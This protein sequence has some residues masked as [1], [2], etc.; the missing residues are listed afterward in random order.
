MR[1]F[2]PAM[3][4]LLLS[5]AALAAPSIPVNN[6]N[7]LNLAPGDVTAFIG[8]EPGGGTGYGSPAFF[9][10]GEHVWIPNT[11]LGGNQ[12]HT[13]PFLSAGTTGN[14]NVHGGL[15]QAPYYAGLDLGQPREIEDVLVQWWANEGTSI[16]KFT[17]QGS[18]DKVNWTD[19]AV[20]DYGSYVQG[21]GQLGGTLRTNVVLST[22]GEYRYVRVYVAAGDYTHRILEPMDSPGTYLISHERG[23]PGLYSIEPRGDGVL[24]PYQTNLANNN[25]FATSVLNNGLVFNGTRYNDGY[26]FDDEAT[27][28]G[29]DDWDADDFIQLNLGAVKG[30]DRVILVW[31]YVWQGNASVQLQYSVDGKNFLNVPSPMLTPLPGAMQVDFGQVN[32][33]YVRLVSASGGSPWELINQFMVYNI[34]EPAAMSLLAMGGLLVGRRVR[35]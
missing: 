2:P 35:R 10:W 1:I 14:F 23:G 20:H 28:T 7:W 16:K 30:I 4:T 29:T 31:D 18:N 22:P 11:T 9:R 6:Y 21:S 24:Y 34:P 33:Q 13:T 15:G 26:L 27:R 12:S 17:L 25:T 32:A 5:S 19:L 8:G 3:G